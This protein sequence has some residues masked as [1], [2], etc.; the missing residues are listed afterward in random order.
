MSEIILNKKI[1]KQIKTHPLYSRDKKIVIG[2]G[3][4]ERPEFLILGEAP[5]NHEN[6]SGYPFVGRAGTALNFWIKET[7]VNSVYISNVVPLIP[8]KDKF[9]I[10]K[11]TKSEICDFR[12]FVEYII[13]KVNP[14]Y[15]ITLGDSATWSLIEKEVN[16]VKG[17]VVKYG[18]RP[19][20]GI[21]HPARYIRL[22]KDN[23][24]GLSDFKNAIKL[25]RNYK[26]C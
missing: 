19:L 12:D 17:K 22:G 16:K 1:I 14:K 3:E 9:M 25:L 11:P 18:V 10:R 7:G 8:L 26:E 20:T 15:I 2:R 13:G 21:Y 5:G 23:T 4:A 24:L 6:F